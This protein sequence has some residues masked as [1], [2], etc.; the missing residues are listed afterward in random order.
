M[1]DDAI[2]AA[3]GE[4]KRFLKAVEAFEAAERNKQEDWHSSPKESGA[5]RR[6]SMDL[7]RAL[8]EMRKP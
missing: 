2:R 3:K 4:A 5:M 8:A 6:A 7:T 1:R